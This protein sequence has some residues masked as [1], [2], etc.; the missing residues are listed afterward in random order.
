M[1]T[2]LKRFLEEHNYEASYID[3]FFTLYNDIQS[4]ECMPLTTKTDIL[5]R[6]HDVSELLLPYSD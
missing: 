4:D 1:R 3:L 5:Q 6:L 2:M